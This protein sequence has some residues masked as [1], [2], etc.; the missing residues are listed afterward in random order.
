MCVCVCDQALAFCCILWLHFKSRLHSKQLSTQFPLSFAIIV[1]PRQSPRCDRNIAPASTALPLPQ[2]VQKFEA[3]F[4]L[5]VK[6][7]IV[8]DTK[9][10]RGVGEFLHAVCAGLDADKT[11]SEDSRLSDT[12]RYFPLLSENSLENRTFGIRNPVFMS[13]VMWL[14]DLDMK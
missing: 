8:M 7:G 5:N 9:F 12:F 1:V 14:H 13:E 2:L 4:K 11:A 3:A 6:N 10:A